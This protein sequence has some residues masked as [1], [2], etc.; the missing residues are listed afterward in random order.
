MPAT[1]FDLTLTQIA[2][3]IRLS[4]QSL[5]RHVRDHTPSLAPHRFTVLAWL[6]QGPSTAR[7]LAQRERVSAPSMSRTINELEELGLLARQLDPTDARSKIVTLTPAGKRA[8]S[9]GRRERDEYVAELLQGCTPEELEVL[10]A[11]AELLRL[12]VEAEA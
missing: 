12:V 3:E 5:A 8:L 9:K 2:R 4:S 10:R 7:E 6:E 1:T 11:G